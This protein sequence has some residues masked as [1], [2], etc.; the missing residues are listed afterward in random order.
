MGLSN[1]LEKQT[2]IRP[3]QGIYNSARNS[4]V[5]G[6]ISGIFVGLLIGLLIGLVIGLLNLP[7]GGVLVGTFVGLVAGLLIGLSIGLTNGGV[8]CIQ[9]IILRLFLWGGGYVPLGYVRFLDYA[10]ERILLRKVGGGYIFAH[11]L[12]L[13]YFVSLDTSTPAADLHPATSSPQQQSI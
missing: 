2:L 11:R 3:N 4:I 9:Y 1:L 13:D 10:A 6:L 8:A 12:L 5:V 7:I